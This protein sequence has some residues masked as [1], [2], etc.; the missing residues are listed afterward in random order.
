[1]DVG[2]SFLA[3]APLR[4]CGRLVIGLAVQDDV[5][6]KGPHG[7]HLDLRRCRRHHNHG[8]T[9]KALGTEGHSLGMVACA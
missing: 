7:P 2:E 3:A 1:M 5:S 6:I 8:T 9:A 4:F